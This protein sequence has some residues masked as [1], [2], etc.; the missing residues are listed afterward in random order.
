[1]RFYPQEAKNAGGTAKEC[2]S[3]LKNGGEKD[4]THRGRQM[5]S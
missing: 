4:A 3:Y 1:M 5:F 2:Q